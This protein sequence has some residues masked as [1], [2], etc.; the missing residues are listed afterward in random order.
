[1]GYWTDAMVRR[2][3]KDSGTHI[4]EACGFDE[5]DSSN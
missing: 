4:F 5:V 1:M 3:M 2:E